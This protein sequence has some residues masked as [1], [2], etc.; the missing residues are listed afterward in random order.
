MK[1]NKKWRKYEWLV[2][3]MIHNDY[4]SKD[5]EVQYDVKIQGKLSEINRQV[6]IMIIDRREEEVKKYIIDCKYYSKVIDIKRVESF[7][8]MCNDIKADY[9]IMI[10]TEG[11]TEGAKK[12][13]EK[14]GNITLETIDW[15]K[16]YS[17]ISEISIPNYINEE[18]Y[19]CS[20]QNV[21][22]IYVPGIILWNLGWA[23]EVD[24]ILYL[25]GVGK[26]LKCKTDYLYCDSCGGVFEV[27]KQN[28]ICPHCDIDYSGYKEYYE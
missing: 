10:S 1:E 28:Y 24:G 18:C 7:L 17:Q 3:R 27:K 15:E 19:K 25:F 11:Y 4:C 9:G 20:E 6:D 12:R 2:A 22:D 5:I 26:C 13:V 14:L 16:A 21:N 8:G 23:L